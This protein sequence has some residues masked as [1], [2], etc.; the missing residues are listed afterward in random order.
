MPANNLPAAKNYGTADAANRVRQIGEATYTYDDQGQVTSKTTAQGTS[1]YNWD[2]RGRLTQAVLP[3]GQSVGYNYDALGRLAKRTVG[4]QQIAYLYDGV[5]VVADNNSDGSTT[6]YLNGAGV[7]D[8]LRQS[9]ASTG[10]LYFQT[11]HLGSTTA[12]TNSSGNVAERQSYTP[13]GQTTGS[14]LTR[15]GFTGR[16]RDNVTGLTNFRARWYDAEQGRFMS[17]DPIGFDGGMNFYSYAGNSP[18]N[19]VDPMGTSALTFTKGLIAGAGWSL[20]WALAGSAVAALASCVTGGAA[21]PVIAAALAALAGAAA[22]AA[23]Y[24][25]AM[26]LAEIIVD[27]LMGTDCP[28][29]LHYRIGHMIG[30]FIGG[31]LGGKIGEGFKF[32]FVAGTLVHTS[33]GVKKIEDIKEGDQLLTY[34]QQ[35]KQLEYQSVLQTFTRHA[36]DVLSVKVAGESEPI[37]VTSEHPFFVRVHGARSDTSAEDDGVWLKSGWLKAGDEIRL[38]DGHWAKVQSV[39]FRQSEQVYNFEV[40]QNHNYFVGEQGL[41]VHNSCRG[42]NYPSRVRKGTKERLENGARGPDGQLNCQ[43]CGV[44]LQPGQGTPEHIPPLVETHNNVG[45]NTDQATRNN[46]FNDTAKEL[47]CIG[48]QKSQGGSMT[49]RYRTDIGPALAVEIDTEISAQRVV[50]ILDQIAVW[51][52]LPVRIRFD[53][54]PELTALAVADWAEEKGVA[55]E[56]IKP[57]RPMQNGFLERFN[58]SYGAIKKIK[59]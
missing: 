20:V 58:R 50:R 8:K 43:N 51:R 6:E 38:A 32:C 2:A 59:P 11:D 31:A 49:Q 56:F 15:Y 41:L 47:H 36:D 34:N 23:I 40:A 42:D 1:S 4:S 7:D 28:D 39:E 52:G 3:G 24:Q 18:T 53:N 54:G 25:A 17:E 26:E 29:N 13:F 46:L 27:M 10:S 57:G 48:C 44:Q 12:L 35:S 45:Y 30:D 55:L 19:F 21:A 14:N 22:A 37:G 9:T 33:D 5:D 16:E